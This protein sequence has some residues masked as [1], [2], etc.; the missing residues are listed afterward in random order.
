MMDKQRL[1]KTYR[2]FEHADG[3]QHIA[4]EF[5]VLKLS[6]LIS[7]FDLKRVL[8]VGLGIG[9]ISGTI[10]EFH[11]EG[12]QCYSG[13]EENSFCL[14]AL[15]NNLGDQ[16]AKLNIYSEIGE[17]TGENEFDLVIIDGKDD[18]LKEVKKLLSENGIIAIEG[19]RLSQQEIL[20]EVFPAHKY[21]HSISKKK[22]SISSPFASSHWQ[23]G[24]KI[25]FSNPSSK[26]KQWWMK[27]K[28]F[29]KLKYF[30]RHF[31]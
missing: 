16:Y 21:V 13:T 8:E 20:K 3:N 12:I 24:I 2:K 27:E 30:Y 5:A 14:E 18:S 29:T 11:K 25:I 23:G 7:N 10:L 26:Q 9:S 19:D 17:I 4:S 22:N 15:V 1:L 31:N 28:I 6:E